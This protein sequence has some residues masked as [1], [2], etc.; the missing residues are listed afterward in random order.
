MTIGVVTAATRR[1]E[2]EV[3]KCIAPTSIEVV[4]VM[5]EASIDAHIQTCRMYVD[6]P[7]DSKEY[8]CGENKV[9]M[10]IVVLRVRKSTYRDSGGIDSSQSLY[11]VPTGFKL[12]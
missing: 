2:L 8:W 3:C 6:D 10:G 7:D 12:G 5:W 9:V 11:E 1:L 4:T